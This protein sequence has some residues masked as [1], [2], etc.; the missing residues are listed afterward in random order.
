MGDV[1]GHEANKESSLQA[2]G[3]NEAAGGL[4]VE[5]VE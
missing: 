3:W 4:N 2:L 5:H 1:G